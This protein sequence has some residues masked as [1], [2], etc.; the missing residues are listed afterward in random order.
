MATPNV[1]SSSLLQNVS[2]Y[3]DVKD[4]AK[5]TNEDMGKQ[6]FL[7]LFTAQLQNQNPLEPV[8]NEAFVAQLAQFSQLEALTN[9][10]G[11]LDNFVKSYSGER[12]LGSAALIGKKVS[13]IDTPTQLTSGG[14]IDGSIDLPMGASQVQLSVHDSQGRLVQELVAGPQLPGTAPVS[15]NGKDATD[16]P[17]PSGLYRLSAT[18][19]V[20]GKSV[21]VPVSTLSTVRAIS[22]NPAD[23]SV[24]VEVDGGK[25]MLLTD[26]KRVGS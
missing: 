21:P 5:K 9:M 20:N 12:M 4:A 1:A 8:K 11:S 3:E 13:V 16:K 24:S 26:V 25:T 6:E 18:A 23:G 17:A 15:W 2:R 14:V 7:T 10:Q 19:T 22:S